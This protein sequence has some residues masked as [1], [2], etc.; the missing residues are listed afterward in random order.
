MNGN[1]QKTIAE[2]MQ[3]KRGYLIENLLGWKLFYVNGTVVT[4]RDCKFEDAPQ[5]GVAVF[6]KYHSRPNNRPYREI[7]FGQ[8][9]YVLFPFDALD[10]NLPPQVKA[11]E[12]THVKEFKRMLAVAQADDDMVTEMRTDA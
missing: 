10:A 8:D 3:E 11:G 2:T 1:V 4:S 9:L 7:Q 12:Y 6:I 5:R